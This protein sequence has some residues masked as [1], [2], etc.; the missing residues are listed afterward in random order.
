[1]SLLRLPIV[2]GVAA[3]Y[4]L[5]CTAPA[6]SA[7]TDQP[8]PSSNETLMGMYLKTLSIVKIICWIEAIVETVSTLSF[9]VSDDA[10]P[11]AISSLRGPY[12]PE[13]PS[14]LFVL[15][16]IS[17]LLGG[18]LRFTCYRMLGQSFTFQLSIR[19]S[20]ALVTTG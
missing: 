16:G 12:R 11:L 2:I 7:K 4:H 15:A 1:M 17:S 19:S 3:G 10:V 8:T 6:Q 20:H 9:Y 14:V 5:C 18:L 13:P